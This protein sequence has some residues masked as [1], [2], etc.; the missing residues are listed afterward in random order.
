[1]K[2]YYFIKGSSKRLDWMIK[3]ITAEIIIL[4]IDHGN[5]LNH[6]EEFVQL[7]T[8]PKVKVIC[9]YYEDCQ[10]VLRRKQA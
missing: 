2:Y 8:F 7:R 10:R 5:Y 4:F 1:M 6:K 9:C 3:S